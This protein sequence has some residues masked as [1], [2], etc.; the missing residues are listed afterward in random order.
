MSEY[1]KVIDFNICSESDV[2]VPSHDGLFYTNVVAMRIASGKNQILVPSH[3]I[4]ANNLNA[5]SDDFISPY[6]S[7]KTHFAY[8]CFC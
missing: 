1:E 2:F 3:E 6:V 5:A 4:A 7:H 8:S